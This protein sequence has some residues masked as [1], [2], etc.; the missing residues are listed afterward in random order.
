VELTERDAANPRSTCRAERHDLIHFTHPADG[1]C[2]A[3]GGHPGG[4]IRK[5]DASALKKAA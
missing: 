2:G 4:G 5:L 1:S 3:A